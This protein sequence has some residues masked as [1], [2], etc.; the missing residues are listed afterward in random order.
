[1]CQFYFLF[2]L[3]INLNLKYTFISFVSSFIC[4][5]FPSLIKKRSTSF[6][7]IFISETLQNIQNLHHTFMQTP[8]TQNYN[9]QA[10]ISFQTPLFQNKFVFFNHIQTCMYHWEADMHFKPSSSITC[11]QLLFLNSNLH[12]V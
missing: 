6:S 5:L 3:L 11:M 7:F 10:C 2:F 8:Q 12:H 1:M 9:L 4:I